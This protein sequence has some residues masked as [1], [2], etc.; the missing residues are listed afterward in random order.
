MLL[1]GLLLEYTCRRFAP[2]KAIYG[3]AIWIAN[4]FSRLTREADLRLLGY[5]AQLT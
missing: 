3:E 5:K 2:D 1:V 4:T